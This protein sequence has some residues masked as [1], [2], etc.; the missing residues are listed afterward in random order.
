MSRR[1]QFAAL[2]ESAPHVLPS[3]LMSDFGDLRREIEQLT[4]AGCQVL[5][6]DVMDGQ[7]V[8]NF[9][10]GMPVVAGIKKWSNQLLDV[11]LMTQTPQKYLAE[12]YEAGA[13]CL[14][15]HVEAVEDPRPTLKA[16]RDLGA[17]A[18]IALNPSTPVDLI[19]ECLDLCDLVLVMSVEAGF[20]GQA[21]QEVALERLS[22]LRT[23]VGPEVLLEVDGGV[24]R[25]TIARCAAAGADLFVAGSAIFGQEEYDHAMR[26][27]KDLAQLE[28]R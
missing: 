9:T 13:D 25:D 5:H 15:I 4:L 16:I 8:P 6:L 11:H 7:F 14:T 3:I 12:F 19:E 23:Q 17:A 28:M 27:L 22:W 10:F 24:N 26:D 18:G 21:F 2:R 20:G 1:D